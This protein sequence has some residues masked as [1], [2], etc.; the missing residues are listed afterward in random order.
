MR[1]AL[2]RTFLIVAWLLVVALELFIMAAAIA[3]GSDHWGLFFNPFTS[4]VMIAWWTFVT[5]FTWSVPLPPRIV[6][7]IRI[8]ELPDE[9]E[10]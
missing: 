2:K 9:K 6:I 3:R 5:V 10:N 8:I 4:V 1:L 7:R